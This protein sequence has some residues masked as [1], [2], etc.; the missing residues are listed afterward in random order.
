MFRKLLFVI[1]LVLIA[2]PF[3]PFDIIPAGSLI[4][5]DLLNNNILS[6]VIGAIIL[7]L[8]FWS[9]RK[10]KRLFGGS[11]AGPRGPGDAQIMR[12]ISNSDLRRMQDV[13][14]LRALQ[15]A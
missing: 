15:G 7:L 14:R 11:F 1:G 3:L 5:I 8:A 4:G 12:K 2:L 10:E 9:W 13:Q 6:V